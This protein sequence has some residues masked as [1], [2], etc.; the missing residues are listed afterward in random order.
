MLDTTKPVQWL[1]DSDPDMPYRVG[2]I[3]IATDGQ[4]VERESFNR[5]QYLVSYY[6]NEMRYAWVGCC[7]LT[8][9]PTAPIPEPTK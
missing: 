7:W 3:V 8:N 4:P 5:L 1:D 9:Y 2:R 6:H